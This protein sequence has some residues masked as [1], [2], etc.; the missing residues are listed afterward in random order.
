MG[1][2]VISRTP[3]IALCRTFN[4]PSRYVSGYVPDVA[5]QDNGTP[6]DF[7][8]YFEV[9][10]SD[11]WHVFDARFNKPRIWAHQDRARPGRGGRRVCHHLRR[12]KMGAF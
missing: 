2:A 9:Y 11:G 8:A 10:L 3:A 1:F 6:M 7:H 5:W 4:L 12:G